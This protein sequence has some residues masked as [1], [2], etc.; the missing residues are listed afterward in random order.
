M[1]IFKTSSPDSYIVSKGNVS[2]ILI[3]KGMG[4]YFEYYKDNKLVSELISIVNLN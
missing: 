3:R 2:G 1:T 4:W